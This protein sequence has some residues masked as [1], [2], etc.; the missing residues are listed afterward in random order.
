LEKLNKIA[1]ICRLAT[2]SEKKIRGKVW[3][4]IGGLISTAGLLRWRDSGA[5]PEAANEETNHVDVHR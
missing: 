5:S 3:P 1:R 4:R 2:A